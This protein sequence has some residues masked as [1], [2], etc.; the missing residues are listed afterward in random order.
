M[1]VAKVIDIKDA[2]V[3]NKAKPIMLCVWN[4]SNIL[5]AIGI[6]IIIAIIV[7]INKAAAVILGILKYWLRIVTWKKCKAVTRVDIEKNEND[8]I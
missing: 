4:L 5:P 8:R 1:F 7:G 6:N 2:V 3:T